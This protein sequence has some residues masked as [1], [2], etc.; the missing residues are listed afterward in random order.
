MLMSD[1]LHTNQAAF[2][3]FHSNYKSKSSWSINHPI[4]NTEYSELFLLYDPVHLIKNIR[5]NWVT[6]KTQRLRFTNLDTGYSGTARWDD[7]KK[8]YEEDQRK[9]LK[10]TKLDY[11]T[12]YP[13]N[14]DKQ[15]VSL[16]LNVFNEKTSAALRLKGA[17]DTEEFV[18]MVTKMWNILNV[19]SKTAAKN[20][21]DPNRAPFENAL[22]DRLV[23]L[24]TMATTFKQMDTSSQRNGR[25]LG[26]TS[27]TSNALHITLHRLSSL[28]PVLLGKGMIYVILGQFQSDRIEKEFG[29]YR[30]LSGG[31]YL[32]SVMQVINS[33]ALQRLHLFRTL[34]MEKQSVHEKADLRKSS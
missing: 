16:A 2:S 28:V 33:L 13:S 7:L 15:E 1:N 31:N 3:K 18:E 12:I 25:I 32:I 11:R 17:N 21:N 29:I 22:D 34:D 27:D 26:L 14:F 23:H 10:L 30:K 24:K 4:P 5:N 9:F 20:L 8:V 6:E 19:K